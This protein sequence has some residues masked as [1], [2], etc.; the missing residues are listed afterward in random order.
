M[1]S[2]DRNWFTEQPDVCESDSD[3]ALENLAGVALRSAV[4]FGARDVESR[5][6]GQYTLLGTLIMFATRLKLSVRRRVNSSP[7]R[8]HGSP[9]KPTFMGSHSI[10]SA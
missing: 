5:E 4:S 6:L 9:S 3:F 7:R 2:M 1:L 8:C 10:D